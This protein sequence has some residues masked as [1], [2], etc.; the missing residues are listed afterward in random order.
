MILNSGELLKSAVSKS[1]KEI[2]CKSKKLRK[3]TEL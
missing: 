2:Q 1:P 3:S